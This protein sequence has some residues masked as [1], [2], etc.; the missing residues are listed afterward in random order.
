M[1]QFMWE[2]KIKSETTLLCNLITEIIL[3]SVH[4]MAI[5]AKVCHVK[6]NKKVSI[7]MEGT[8][9]NKILTNS[10]VFAYE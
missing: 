9:S 5:L 3:M 6:L 1:D 8:W 4:N 10:C 2:K 7:Y